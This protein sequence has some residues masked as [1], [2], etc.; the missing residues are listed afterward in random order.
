MAVGVTSIPPAPP[1]PPSHQPSAAAC[2]TEKDR[3]PRLKELVK[4]D[5]HTYQLYKVI[6]EGGYGTVY[7]SE[8]DD[9]RRVAVKAEKYSKSMLHIEASVM[10]A[11][12]R[13][14]SEHICELIDYGSEK[15]DYIFIV[16]PLLGKDLHKLRNEQINR[17]FSLCTAVQVGL[18]TLKAIEELHLSHFI[19]RDI[20]PGNFMVGLRENQ[21]HKTIFLIDF[22][23]AKKYVDKNGKLL[24][25]RGEVGW[26]GTTR[27][28]SLKAHL[29]LDLARRDDLESWFY[30]LVEITRGSLPWRHVSERA[31]VQAAKLMARDA[32]RTQFFHQCPKQYE[33]LMGMVDGLVFEDSPKYNEF[34]D[35]L[36]DIKKEWKLRLNS[37]F[38]WDEDLTSTRSTTR[39][40]SSDAEC[41]RAVK[42]ECVRDVAEVVDLKEREMI[43][44]KDQQ[45]Q[46]QQSLT[47]AVPLSTP[48]LPT[49]V[50]AL[51]QQRRSFF[52]REEQQSAGSL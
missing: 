24:P 5:L 22:G 50:S 34:E 21:Q 42:E 31:G 3:L 15:P 32:G 41:E 17:R 26:R 27:Y 2:S 19:S 43:E 7:E 14:H 25:S 13:R 40:I 47:G 29:R 39:S 49:A 8:T 9:G 36:M 6:G 45:K 20:K 11:A 44:V 48:V 35:V 51:R 12:A 16:I 18:Q 10:R 38:D 33:T 28:G 1:P 4:T 52:T 37:R 46:P 30:L 23:L